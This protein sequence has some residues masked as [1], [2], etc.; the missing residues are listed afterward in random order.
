M[1]IKQIIISGYQGYLNPKRR[2]PRECVLYFLISSFTGSLLGFCLIFLRFDPGLAL[3]S[4]GAIATLI[5]IG[6]FSINNL[7]F[8]TDQALMED[9]IIQYKI[10]RIDLLYGFFQEVQLAYSRSGVPYSG[11]GLPDTD[12]VEITALFQK[13]F[14]EDGLV[15]YAGFRACEGNFVVFLSRL[16][17]RH[18]EIL[19]RFMMRSISGSNRQ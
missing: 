17:P 14:R 8:K 4:S 15:L 3:L 5:F 16:E 1:N 9:M 2:L 13:I 19:Y 6:L 11:A 18:R 7:L 12:Q 10:D